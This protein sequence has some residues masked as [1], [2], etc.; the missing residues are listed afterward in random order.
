MPG[1]RKLCFE[2]RF[3]SF[4][5]ICPDFPGRAVKFSDFRYVQV[6][7]VSRQIRIA[8]QI[9][10]DLSGR[11]SSFPDGPDDERLSSAHIA[12]CEDLLPVC[13]VTAVFCGHIGTPV[14]FDAEGFQNLRLRSRKARCDQSDL[15]GVDFFR[16][17]DRAQTA[18]SRLRIFYALHAD[19]LHA[20]EFSVLAPDKAVYRGAVQA[21]IL[22]VESD[23]FLRP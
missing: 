5:C 14:R 13:A 4:L 7:G 18:L 23:R 20:G 2:S 1:K 12:G 22:S 3:P 6:Y 21:G 19:D 10:V 16:S 15:C 8:V 9:F 17:F 11:F